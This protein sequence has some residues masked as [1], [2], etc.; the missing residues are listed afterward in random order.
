MMLPLRTK[1]L[2]IIALPL[3]GIYGL[4]IGYDYFAGRRLA[5]DTVKVTLAA[6]A[7]HQAAIVN[8]HFASLAQVAQ[9]M[10]TFFPRG[11]FSGSE[12]VFP[13]LDAVA[14]EN[15][16][17]YGAAVAFDAYRFDRKK[18]FFAP[19]VF[20]VTGDTRRHN[21]IA[22][23][24]NYDYQFYDWFLIPKLTNA[25]AWT[26]PYVDASAQD[27]LV[28]SFSAPILRDAEFIGVTKV[29]TRVEAIRNELAGM[30]VQDGFTV[31][32]SR[33]GTIIAHL[34]P[35]YILRH[36]LVSLAQERQSA[37][38]E[39]LAHALLRKGGSGVV[40]LNATQQD[41]AL[42]LAYAPVVSTGW[43]LLV[44]VPEAAVFRDL[45]SSLWMRAGI[46]ACSAV[47]LFLLLYCLTAREVVRPLQSLN[48]A[49]LRLGG[50]DLE[51]GLELA[52]TTEEVRTVV[53]VYNSMVARLRETLQIRAQDIAARRL[54]EEENQAKSEFLARMSHEIR[55]PMNG[56]VGMSHLAL[57]HDLP[58]K[59][60]RYL[61]TI[62]S[63]ALALLDVLNAILDFSKVQTGAMETEHTPF[64]L[65]SLLGALHDGVQKRAAAKGLLFELHIDE[66]LPEMLVGDAPHLRQILLHLLHN[67][68]KF[69]EQ[70]QVS[71]HV[72]AQE[73]SE[74]QVSVHF[75]VRDTGIGIAPEHQARI[76]EGF[77]QVDGSMTRRY[78]GSGLGL[79]LS[80]NMAELMRGTLRV[81][82]EPGR[83]STFHLRLP[84]DLFLTY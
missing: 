14:G 2:A 41:E 53:D 21:F 24:Y 48:A 38:L 32:A 7:A 46:L 67:A 64:G 28:V 62:H 15:S 12:D 13:L 19:H 34:N 81:E 6:Q 27:A 70:G 37:E 17:I 59:Q 84:F 31:L 83:G 43:T 4:L 9:T 69:T 29:D 60:K 25:P 71:L 49:A 55:T 57:Q 51:S 66:A 40:R 36:T 76:F 58:A 10:S 26:D 50:G 45:V 30:R 8:G 23:E 47:L 44:I 54:A 5:V 42:W 22:P 74:R 3:I 35:E 20:R 52:A 1:I 78:G 39:E 65:R 79:A 18:Q 16:A 75:L 56:I 68:I 82:S 77:T 72:Q 73:E 33:V 11:A 63:S 61:E 80:K